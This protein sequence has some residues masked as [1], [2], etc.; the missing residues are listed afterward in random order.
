MFA[1]LHTSIV[2]SLSIDVYPATP[3]LILIGLASGMDLVSVAEVDQHFF[4]TDQTSPSPHPGSPTIGEEFLEFQ[5][6]NLYSKMLYVHFTDKVPKDRI[7]DTLTQINLCRKKA[8]RPRSSRSDYP[9][10][11]W[12]VNAE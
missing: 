7:L 3:A 12:E 1:N 2:Y 5:K 4:R 8:Q 10:R 9:Q 11:S 6:S